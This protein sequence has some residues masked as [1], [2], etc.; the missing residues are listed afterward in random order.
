MGDSRRTVN[1]QCS[2]MLA[3]VKLWVKFSI[4]LYVMCLI[5]RLFSTLSHWLGALQIS[6]I[7]IKIMFVV[8]LT[9]HEN[10]HDG[11]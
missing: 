4:S 11:S 7:I 10:C 2:Y 8:C 3:F 6:I 9:G 5:L 1:R